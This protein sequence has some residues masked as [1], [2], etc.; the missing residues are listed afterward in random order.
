MAHYIL[1]RLLY[2][3][4]V[5]WGALTVIFLVVRILPGDPASMMLGAGA[6]QTEIDALRQNLGLD[7]S[8][9]EQYVSFMSEAARLDFGESLWLRRPVL[10]SIGER[11]AAT[12]RLAIAAV[13]LAVA[14]SFPLGI[15]AA[16][17]QRGPIDYA[18]SV[19]SLI[20]QS[21]PGFW[22]GIMLILI[23]ARQLR[24]LPSAGSQTPQHLILPAI[25]LALPLV[26]VLTRLVRSGLLEV[27]HEDYIR[28][29]RAKGI[30]PHA[31]LTRHAM[32]NMLIPV[33]TVLG[34]QLG[35]LLGGAVIVETVFGWPGI[36]RL[37]V[38]AITKRDY[39][40]VQAAI[41]FITTTFV[42]INLIVDLSYVYL[43]PRIRLR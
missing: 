30:A 42:L 41:L 34:I 29:A 21:V 35:N 36:G 10:D 8:L 40:L 11:I 3:V 14:I 26:G 23:F 4:F 6:T 33:I 9:P 20:G 13:I 37:L 43:D 27:M 24:W 32:R 39:P 1:Q 2:A 7:A 18:V 28:T 12:G 25:T 5:L 22:L 15:V 16:L 31:V 19:L 17:R 38:D